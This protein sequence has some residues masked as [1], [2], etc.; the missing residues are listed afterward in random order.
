[1]HPI[2]VLIEKTTETLREYGFKAFFLK[3][4]AY[5]K[6]TCSKHDNSENPQK[7]FMDVLFINGCYLPHPSRY[8][9]SHQREQ[10]LAYGMPTNE[11][12]FENLTLDLVKNYRLF[13]FY[14]CPYTETI[15]EFIRLAKANNKVVLFDVDDLVIDTKYTDQIKFIQEMS[16]Q[17]KANYDS[18]VN[19]M[20]QTLCLCDGAITTTERLAAEL[21]NYVPEVFIN[22]NVASERMLELSNQA[23]LERDVLPYRNPSEAK[24]AKER[25][26]ISAA[27]TQAAQRNNGKVRLGYFSGSI[28][29]NDD[30][31]LI[32]PVLVQTLER[33]PNVELHIVGELDLPDALQPYASRIVARPFVDWEKLPD[34]IASVD[35]NL[36]PLEDTIFNEAKSENKWVEAALVKVPTIASRVGAFE[37]MMEDGK[38]G[39]LCSTQEEWAHALDLLITDADKRRALAHAAHAWAIQNACTMYTGAHLMRYLRQRMTPNFV[40]VLP[41]LQISGGI[42]VALQHCRVMRN[43]GYDVTIVNDGT[44]EKDMCYGG[45]TFF[46]ISNRRRE[47]HASIDKAVATLWSTVESLEQNPHIRERYY[48]VQGFETNFTQPGSFFRFQSNRTYCLQHDMNYVTVSKWCQSWLRDS[49]FQDAKYAPNGIIRQRFTPRVRTFD[50]GKIRILVEGNC[51]DSFKN[52]DESFRIVEKLD[53][54]KFE[55]WYMS[56]QGKPK[57]WYRVD[58]FFHR[59]SNEKVSEIYGACDILI[60][61]SIL[62]SFSYPPLEMMATGGYAVVAPNEG[63]VEYLVDGE[64]CLMYHNHNVDEA[65]ACIERLCQDQQLR[66]HLYDNGLQTACQRDWENIKNDIL[67]LYGAM[68]DA[69]TTDTT[70]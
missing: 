6:K 63:N 53:P 59:I 35:I 44:D 26:A 52:V 11:V 57:S 4:L 56:Y 20:K 23:V 37:R 13:I 48:L 22:R 60:K 55:V 47:F 33:H 38:T 42:L 39:L 68:D 24:N 45:E 9:V 50:E 12:F 51:D 32:L 29:H 62:E 70:K 61:S 31:K 43:A 41:S 3:T 58:Q 2:P 17:D 36:A 14:R 67:N 5:L 25:R 16:A 10:L 40:M 30:V 21:R 1:M 27:R 19:R 8:R 15:G 46:A 64:N 69:A 7:T 54:N 28:T 18:G 49:Y 65:V 34:L 66:Q